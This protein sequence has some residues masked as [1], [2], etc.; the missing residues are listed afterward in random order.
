MTF[1]LWQ[2]V[3]LVFIVVLICMIPFL[4]LEQD[5]EDRDK[6][7]CEELQNAFEDT[8]GKDPWLMEDINSVTTSKIRLDR[9]KDKA[10]FLND[11]YLIANE[12]KDAPVGI[13]VK[14]TYE[15]VEPYEFILLPEDLYD[16]KDLETNI[17]IMAQTIYGEARDMSTYEMSLVAWCICNRVDSPHFPSTIEEVI[18]QKGQFHGYSADKPIEK[19]CFEVAKDVIIRWNM[20]SQIIGNVGRTL[21]KEYLYFY[22]KDGHNKYRVKNDDPNG[23]WD[24]TD[25]LPNPYE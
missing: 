17:A 12:E 24:F 11:I 9:V 7:L 4:I 15:P 3:V 18:K 23:R 14:H 2:V 22:G 1:S 21:P 5:A 13:E 19:R 10:L 6:E 25:I 8:F 16:F 20:E